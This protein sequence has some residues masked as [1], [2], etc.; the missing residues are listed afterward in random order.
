MDSLIL[1]RL[2]VEYQG[3]LRNGV[4]RH[5]QQLDAHTIALEVLPDMQILANNTDVKS[6]FLY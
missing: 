2:I 6:T 1:R 3:L 4:I 5:I